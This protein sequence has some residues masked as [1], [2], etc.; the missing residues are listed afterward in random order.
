MPRDRGRGQEGRCR[1]QEIEFFIE[2][3]LT[4]KLRPEKDRAELRE[5]YRSKKRTD[6]QNTILKYP[7]VRQISAGSLYLYDREYNGEISKLNTERKKFADK[8][9]DEKAADEL[10]RIDERIQ[11]QDALS[12]KVLDTMAKERA[13]SAPPAGGTLHPRAH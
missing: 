8:K 9:D 3:T 7:S 13:T 12:K 11:F 10:K 1:A 4:W 6:P 2:R 5:A